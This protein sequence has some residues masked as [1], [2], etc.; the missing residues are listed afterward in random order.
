MKLL[1]NNL[2]G[3]IEFPKGAVVRVN[4]AWVKSQKDL[5]H[6]VKE[7]A[8]R[9]IFLDFPSGRTK[10]PTPVL[11]LLDLIMTASRHKNIK[12]FAVSNAEEKD[13]LSYIREMLPSYTQLVPK[14]ET[15]NGIRNIESI[16]R[17]SSCKRVMLDKEDLYLCCG[18]NKTLYEN[19]MGVLLEKCRELG[20]RVL[21][22]G[23]VYFDE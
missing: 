8:D 19:S 10:P 11:D 12:Y 14:I 16:I 23:G 6:I 9:D 13:Y 21:K 2:R 20:V 7:N 1:S 17:A 18:A 3:K 4:S 22:L 15:L 5:D